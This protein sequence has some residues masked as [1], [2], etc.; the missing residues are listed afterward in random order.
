M[1]TTSKRNAVSHRK[2]LPDIGSSWSNSWLNA[3]AR[4]QSLAGSWLQT[5]FH[6]SYCEMRV[7]GSPATVQLMISGP[8]FVLSVSLSVGRPKVTWLGPFRLFPRGDLLKCRGTSSRKTSN[9]LSRLASRNTRV[10]CRDHALILLLARL[11][12]RAGEVIALELDDIDWRAGVLTVRGK[13]SYHDRLPLPADVGEAIA[14][15]LHQHRPL[16]A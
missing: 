13:G 11:G 2:R 16:T 10:G 14:I 4:G 6:L 3:L 12:L 5:I 9:E 7:P 15:Y 1:R 8:P